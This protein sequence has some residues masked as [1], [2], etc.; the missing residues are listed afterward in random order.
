MKYEYL[1][2]SIAV[3]LA[4]SALITVTPVESLAAWIRNY[5]GSWSYSDIY[6]YAYGG[7][8]QINGTW[9]YFDPYGLMRTGWILITKSGIIRT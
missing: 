7:W 2:K 5:D 4:V 6:G 1:R 3:S 9:Y 8:K